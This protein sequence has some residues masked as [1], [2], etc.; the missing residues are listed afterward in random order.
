MWRGRGGG[1]SAPPCNIGKE[2]GAP[3]SKPGRG[4]GSRNGREGRQV[5]RMDGGDPGPGLPVA[6]LLPSVKSAKPWRPDVNGFWGNHCRQMW[7]KKP[8]C[9]HRLE[10]KG[11]ES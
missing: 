11:P 5:C 9:V 4:E 2:F 3:R 7:G 1:G 8:M 6:P 10:A